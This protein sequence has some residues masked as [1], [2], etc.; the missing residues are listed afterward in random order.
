MEWNL[1]AGDY[2]PNGT[3]GLTALSGG[4]EV[5]ARVLYRLTAR[6]GAFPF[7]PELLRTQA[8]SV[9]ELKWPLVPQTT[10][11]GYGGPWNEGPR[12]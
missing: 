10:P 6:R 8:V 7:L 3:G 1:G 12:S 11:V 4:E 2:I 5:L 9:Q